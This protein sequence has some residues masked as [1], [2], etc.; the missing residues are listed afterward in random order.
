M[1]VVG[2]LVGRCEADVQL[3]RCQPACIGGQMKVGCDHIKD[4]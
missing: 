3:A 4:T 2:V 1:C